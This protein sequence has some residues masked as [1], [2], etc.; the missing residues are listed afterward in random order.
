MPDVEAAF[1]D[2]DRTL[3]ASGTHVLHDGLSYVLD[4]EHRRFSFT[5]VT[6]RGVGLYQDVVRKNPELV[7]SA[8]LPVGLE[9]G[10]QLVTSTDYTDA[11]C[12]KSVHHT[13][14]SLHEQTE[15]MSL[16]SDLPFL[17][18]AFYGQYPAQPRTLW[19]PSSSQHG[20]QSQNTEAG[21]TRCGP[22]NSLA[23]AIEDAQPG[24]VAVKF[25]NTDTPVTKDVSLTT[26]VTRFSGTKTL[27]FLPANADKSAAV[28]RIASILGLRREAILVGGD[29]LPDLGMLS[30]EGIKAVVVR[31]P[32]VDASIFPAHIDRVEPRDFADY[33]GR[34]K[35][36]PLSEGQNKTV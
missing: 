18:V 35:N 2:I 25:R 21:I 16:I 27:D 15:L 5:E 4:P 30:I 32:N 36:A 24:M 22:I 33:L 14:L 11:S 3:V 10:T 19:F 17:R 13:A 12:Y 23:R 8:G 31:N 20:N 29:S 9:Y 7:P 34:I 1:F 6:A 26:H 28:L